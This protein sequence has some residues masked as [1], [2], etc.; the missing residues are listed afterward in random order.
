MTTTSA[1]DT[2]PRFVAPCGD[3][4]QRRASSRRDPHHKRG[5]LI[6]YYF[7]RAQK[8]CE[9]DWQLKMG[10]GV[11][12]SFELHDAGLGQRRS[13]W[14]ACTCAC[15]YLPKLGRI[16]FR[17]KLTGDLRRIHVLIPPKWVPLQP[18]PGHQIKN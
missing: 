6:G 1:R 7:S 4:F 2:G 17:H 3:C 16:E 5:H 8:K 14:S 13:V 11:N 9:S 12:G 10:V 18:N 15:S